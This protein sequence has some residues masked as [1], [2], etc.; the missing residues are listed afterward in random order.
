MDTS[1]YSKIIIQHIILSSEFILKIL[2]M[3]INVQLNIIYMMKKLIQQKKKKK[4]LEK[5]LKQKI[6]YY[7]DKKEKM[8]KMKVKMKYNNFYIL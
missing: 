2:I 4:H 5:F 8:K 6:K 1:E 7:L 3:N